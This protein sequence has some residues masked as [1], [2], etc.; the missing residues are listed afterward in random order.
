V[1]VPIIE[2][3]TGQVLS[4]MG[5]SVQLMDMQTYETFEVPMPQEEEIRTK[6][7]PGVEVEYWTML[8]RNKIMRTKG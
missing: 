7:T 2:K 3:K 1:E 5:D 8:G 6:L 4:V